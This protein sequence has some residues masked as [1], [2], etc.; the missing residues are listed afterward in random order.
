MDIDREDPYTGRID[1][2]TPGQPYEKQWYMIYFDVLNCN[3]LGNTVQFKKNIFTRT[4]YVF[5]RN[6]EGN[7]WNE[8]GYGWGT[9]EKL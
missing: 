8:P 9:W 1:G 4:V 5:T 3:R 6:E 2:K 7:R